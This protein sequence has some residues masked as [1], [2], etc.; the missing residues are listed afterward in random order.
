MQK[1]A[2]KDFIWPENP[3][4][5]TLRYLRRPQYEKDANGN[6]VYLGLSLARRQ[7]SGHG[8]FLGPLAYDNFAELEARI[9]DPNAGFLRL[10][11]GDSIQAYFTELK[12]EQDPRPELISYRFTFLETDEAG[13]L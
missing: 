8:V 6:P 2:F 3:E 7:V 11:Q 1:L 9:L 5:I 13:G 10:P 4:A 12:L